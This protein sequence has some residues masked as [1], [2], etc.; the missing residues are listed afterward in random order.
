MSRYSSEVRLLVGEYAAKLLPGWQVEFWETVEDR[1]PED[2]GAALVSWR[3]Y[4]FSCR[5]WLSDDIMRGPEHE[6]RVTI[7]HELLHP[8]F[9][10]LA[11]DFRPDYTDDSRG[12]ARWERYEELIVERIALA[13]A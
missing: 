5:L 10:D 1:A 4:G 9:R 11:E 13:L 12:H 8:L 3:E 6:L 7:I 2:L